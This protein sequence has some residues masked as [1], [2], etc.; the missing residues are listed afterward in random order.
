[1]VI[2]NYH[3]RKKLKLDKNLE[4]FFSNEKVKDWFSGKYKVLNEKEI[5]LPNG[6]VYRPDRIMIHNNRAIV[7]DY[8]FGNAKQ[9]NYHY[10]VR[11]YIRFLTQMGYETEGYLYYV[12]MGEI[13]Q[14]HL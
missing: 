6:S 2:K 5:F 10:Q 9:N 12:A 1:M 8:K 4:S 11:R 13:E 3:I 7:V 14:V